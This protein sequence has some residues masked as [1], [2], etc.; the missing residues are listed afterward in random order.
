M[1]QQVIEWIATYYGGLEALPVHPNTSS[2]ARRAALS[3]E[4]P[5]AGSD[6]VALLDIVRDELPHPAA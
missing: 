4:L 6:F 1:G 2:A 5:E 3:R